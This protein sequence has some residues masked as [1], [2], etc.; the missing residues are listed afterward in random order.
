M[1]SFELYIVAYHSSHEPNAPMPETYGIKTR[2]TVHGRGAKLE[3]SDG[4][5]GN[6]YVVH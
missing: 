5:V 6:E 3:N 1:C 2:F 4:A